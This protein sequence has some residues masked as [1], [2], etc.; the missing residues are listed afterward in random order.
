MSKYISTTY[1]RQITWNGYPA[2][3]MK[4]GLQKYIRRGMIEKALY[5]AGELDLFKEAPDASQ[6][7]G[8]RT[9][10]LHRLMVIFMED[11]ENLSLWPDMTQKMKELFTEREKANRDKAKEERLL[12]EVVIQLGA[13]TKARMCSHIRAVFNPK[14]KPIRGSYPSIQ[15]LWAAIEQNE[16]E[17]TLGTL[18]HNCKLYSKYVKEKNILAVYY[19]FQIEASEEKL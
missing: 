3:V 13:S 4:S 16:K 10:F 8:I 11:V 9:N 7:E 14:Y 6:G 2:D 17:K 18:D 15:P 19:G 5:C 12:S 1:R